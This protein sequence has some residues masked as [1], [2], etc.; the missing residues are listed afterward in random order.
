M[1]GH[2]TGVEPWTFVKSLRLGTREA[3]DALFERPPSCL[4]W[5]EEDY[6][7]MGMRAYLPKELPLTGREDLYGF[8]IGCEAMPARWAHSESAAVL[9]EA[10]EPSQGVW[11]ADRADFEK[12][13]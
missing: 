5:T 1:K 2:E 10:G 3:Y 11:D 8:E 12:I 7:R 4:G 9:V 6:V 13:A